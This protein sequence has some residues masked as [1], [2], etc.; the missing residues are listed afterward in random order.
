MASFLLRNNA[1]MQWRNGFSIQI[2]IQ[3]NRN[4]F[5]FTYNAFIL[6][7]RPAVPAVVANVRP[8]YPPLPRIDTG[9]AAQN[10]RNYATVICG[11]RDAAAGAL[12]RQDG[13]SGVDDI[14]VVPAG[15]PDVN[16]LAASLTD[17]LRGGGLGNNGP[18]GP[19]Y[20]PR[21][22]ATEIG[23]GLPGPV[24][25]PLGGAA[26]VADGDGVPGD[27]HS[28]NLIA[29]PA[30]PA[31]VGRPRPLAGQVFGQNHLL[32]QWNSARTSK[33]LL[34]FMSD[35]KKNKRPKSQH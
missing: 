17:R 25:P 15:A 19:A 7:P 11:V 12:G 30:G 34:K 4:L 23:N 3:K 16:N 28:I 35:A 20:R 2:S 1:M 14:P 10:A 29:P 27:A 26:T 32:P 24:D 21:G 5:I 31:G 8:A 9:R 6:E 33:R 22:G 13:P 18:L